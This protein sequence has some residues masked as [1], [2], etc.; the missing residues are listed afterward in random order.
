MLFGLNDLSFQ[1]T[2]ML[3]KLIQISTKNVF[4]NVKKED[5]IEDNNSLFIFLNVLLFNI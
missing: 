1:Y 3:Y 4:E 2:K 5:L